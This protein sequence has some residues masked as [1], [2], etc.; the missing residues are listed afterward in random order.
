MRANRTV[1]SV[2][3][4]GTPCTHFRRS[5]ADEKR[6]S[7]GHRYPCLCFTRDQLT[8]RPNTCPLFALTAIFALPLLLV[9]CQVE[10]ARIVQQVFTWVGEER[11][12]ING[13]CHRLHQAGIRT[14]T[15]KE[16]WDHKTIWDMLKN[17]ADIGEAAFGKTRW[18]P[19]GPRLRAPRGRPEHSRRGYAGND[20][21]KEEWITIPI[22]AL[23]DADLFQAV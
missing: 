12:T 7:Q 4:P 18:L 19:V 16:H 8:P 6:F 13:A 10:E 15:G 3:Q 11:Y 1:Q 14:Q 22:P 21:P 17:P 20:A 5:I 9:K 2:A 23:V